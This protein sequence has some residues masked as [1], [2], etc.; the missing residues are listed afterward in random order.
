MT[1]LSA[2]TIGLL[3]AEVTRPAY[4]VSRVRRGVV[5]FGLGAFHR[6]HQ[7][8]VFEAALAAGD[9]RWGVVG[10]SLR[11]PAVRAQLAPQDG[12]YTITVRDGAAEAVQL[13]G[14]VRDVLIA[15]DDPAAVVAALARA[16]THLVTL[17]VTEKGYRLDPAS[18]ALNRDDP[19]V[20]AD[21]GDLA[22]PRTVPGLLAAGLAARRRA[23]LAPLTVI[24]CDNLSANGEKLRD[25]VLAIAGA[26]DAG[27]RDWIAAESAF[28]ATMVDRIVPATEP[29][30]IAALARRIGLEDH[31]AV[32]TEPFCQWVIEDRFAGPV[33]DF[34]RFG[35]QLTQA[36]APWEMAKLRLLN[37]AHSAMA[38]LGGLAGLTFVHDFVADRARCRFIERLWDE[39]AATL[40]PPPEL[41]LAGYRAALMTRFGN[42][43]LGHRLR[44]IAADG[45]QKLPQRLLAPMA[46][47]LSRGLPVD[48]LALGVAAWIRWQ[49]GRDEAGKPYRVD[50]PLAAY[51]AARLQGTASAEQRV[52]AIMSLR[53]I[54]PQPLAAQPA[55]A[56][57][58]V[59]ALD[60]IERQGALEAC[61][62]E[63]EE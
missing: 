1:R 18:G 53:E 47:R 17:T 28:P 51:V 8:P 49:S 40:W 60:R 35:V 29:G 62:F 45:S 43:A 54:V 56:A 46:E 12:Y 61:T 11:S 24:S 63:L 58:I 34:S 16:D 4:D 14:A 25:A 32:R 41:D 15:P 52:T 13:V 39:S 36:V 27:L 20:A 7:A 3:P 21:L 19:G 26:H 48:A 22:R 42:P 5:H 6:A 59:R 50:D 30:D 57:A 9:D 31:A 33:P 2:A 37:G 38:Y 23:G 55:A 44:Q 10:V